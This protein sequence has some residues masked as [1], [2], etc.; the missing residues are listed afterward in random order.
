MR[1]FAPILPFL[2]AW[3]LSFVTQAKIRTVAILPPDSLPCMTNPQARQFDFW[4][5]H[6]D[7][8]VT[9]TKKHA[10]S[11]HVEMAA[12]GCAIL[13]HWTSI[14]NAPYT[15]NS[16]N[17]IDPAT[18]K[19]KQVWIGSE[20]INVSEFLHGEYRDD[21]MRFEFATTDTSGKKTLTHFYLFNETLDQ[22]RQLHE[23]SKDDGK[24]WTATY[25]FTYRRRKTKQ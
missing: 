25:D 23:I 16:I 3:A 2:I 13:E 10:G 17:F 4:I 12:G 14:A 19:W 24:T 21:A 15:G 9:G 6:W 1:Y 11:S 8:Y 7:V 18:K 22:V 20:G 5:G